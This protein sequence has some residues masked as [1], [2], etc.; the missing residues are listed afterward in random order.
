MV[1]LTKKIIIVFYSLIGA[2][3]SY[4]QSL[5]IISWN[6]RDC[7]GSKDDSEILFIAKTLRDADLVVIQEVVAVDPAGAQ[8]IGKLADQLNRMGAKW[9]YYFSDPTNSP[10]KGQ[11]ERYAFLWKTSV[12]DIIHRPF[13]DSTL[14][15]QIIR[16]P[17]IGR[18]RQRSNQKQ[19]MVVNFHSRRFDQYPEEE[20]K[21]FYTY[22]KRFDVPVIIAGDFNM[23]ED[24]VVF[25]GLY[26]Q[27]YKSAVTKQKTTLKQTCSNGAYL[28]HAIDNIYV[29]ATMKIQYGGVIDFVKSCGSLEYA[30]TIS[31]HL[32]VRCIISY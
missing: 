11:S 14:A 16:E 26:Q 12:L 17:F 25:K 22:P 31:D 5:N 28:N 21:Y 30:R 13:L 29:P 24:H 27:G 2:L 6:I 8:S 4:S 23:S 32:P 19:F 15:S 10:I 18:F 1:N 7:G 3:P 20:V 9:N